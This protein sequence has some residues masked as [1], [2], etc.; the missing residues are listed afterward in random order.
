MM[1][2]LGFR[3]LAFTLIFMLGASASLAQTRVSF[4]RGKS[5]A[6][7]SGKLAAGAS[8]LYV[9]SA[10]EGQTLTLAAKGDVS[11][12]ILGKDYVASMSG[13]PDSSDYNLVKTGDYKIKIT[14]DQKATNFTLTITLK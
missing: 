7:V 6:S 2:K 4:K 14:S 9:V 5:S 11:Y 12:E 3:S 8:R 13:S 1:K 10:R